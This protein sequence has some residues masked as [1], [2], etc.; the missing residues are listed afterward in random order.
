MS[1]PLCHFEVD[2]H[3]KTKDCIFNLYGEH[4]PPHTRTRAPFLD[5]LCI[6]SIL[7]YEGE[8]MVN[9]STQKKCVRSNMVFFPSSIS[10]PTP[11][12]CVCVWGGGVTRK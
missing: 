4:P 8:E 11:F 5:Q 1:I 12:V 2:L 6:V 7:C 10:L 3:S 9:C